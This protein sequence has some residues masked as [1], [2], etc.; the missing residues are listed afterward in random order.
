MYGTMSGRELK[1]DDAYSQ[2]HHILGEETTP[3]S[4]TMY[5]AFPHITG[6]Q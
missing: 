5:L 1:G 2:G 3:Q 4:I 6:V